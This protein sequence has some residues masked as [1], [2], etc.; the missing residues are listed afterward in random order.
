VYVKAEMQV[1]I[2]SAFTPNQNGLNETFLPQLYGHDLEGCV[3][4]VFDRWGELLFETNSADE[5][6]NG[7]YQEKKV[8]S[9]TYV[10]YVKDFAKESTDKEEFRGTVNII[11]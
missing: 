1:Y 10:Y 5:G 11:Y 9:G 4:Q 2:P 7:I 8:M 6:W 3:L